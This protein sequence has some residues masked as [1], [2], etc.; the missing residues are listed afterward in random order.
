MGKQNF[1]VSENEIFI[2]GIPVDK[3]VFIAYCTDSDEAARRL[4]KLFH[5]DQLVRAKSA[6]FDAGLYSLSRK[7]RR[8]V[9]IGIRPAADQVS[10][11]RVYSS[12]SGL[13]ENLLLSGAA[14]NFFYMHK[15]PGIRL[16]FEASDDASINT[17]RL[18]IDDVM[19]RMK[20]DRLIVNIQSGVYEP[21][22]YL[23]G[24]SASMDH[25]HGL[26][27]I[28]SLF[29]LRH[30]AEIPQEISRSLPVWLIS[31][32]LLHGVFDGLGIDGWEATGVWDCLRT[33]AGRCI[34]G[35]VKALSDFTEVAGALSAQWWDRANLLDTADPE[36]AE[37][38]T[39]HREALRVGARRWKEAY[40][41]T[42]STELGPR[43]A[44]AY[45]VI[46]HWNRAGMTPE[47]QALFAESL[48]EMRSR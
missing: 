4:Q 8:W 23:F 15:P 27:T 9:Q 28:D 18:G 25:V 34:S 31:L 13:A 32:E 46:F 43:Q 14:R 17:V 19:Q 5:H 1:C 45:Y 38:I 3:S 7:S 20:R 39:R 11:R 24:G 10:L 35:E 36:S 12:V 2:D 47:K 6:V 48:A 26:F 37:L 22:T 33:E 29:W 41:A 42:T 30:H 40:F 21:E 44:A 16:R